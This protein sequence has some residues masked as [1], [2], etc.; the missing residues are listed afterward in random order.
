VRPGGTAASVNA[1][2]PGHHNFWPHIPRKPLL[3]TEYPDAGGQNIYFLV[4]DTAA[5]QLQDDELLA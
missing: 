3:L 5:A 4:P 2:G 1:W